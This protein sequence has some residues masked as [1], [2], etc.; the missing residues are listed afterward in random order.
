MNLARGKQ[1]QRPISLS[2]HTASLL[3][4]ARQ[5]GRESA[6]SLHRPDYR[7][8]GRR[9]DGGYCTGDC[10]AAPRSC[11]AVAPPTELVGHG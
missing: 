7:A 6:L 11:S 8:L 9:L 3:L 10:A 5:S 4:S 2:S 1:G